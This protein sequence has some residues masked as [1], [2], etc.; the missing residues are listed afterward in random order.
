MKKLERLCM[1]YEKLALCYLAC[2]VAFQVLAVFIMEMK[3]DKIYV[4]I[5]FLLSLVLA[6][7]SCIK[8]Y[9][10]ITLKNKL[11]SMYYL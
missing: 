4:L 3:Y 10:K 2:A 7:A 9:K 1:E 5:P 6:F 11:K 8:F